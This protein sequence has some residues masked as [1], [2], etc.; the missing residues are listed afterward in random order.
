MSAEDTLSSTG[1]SSGLPLVIVTTL[2]LGVL[3]GSKLALVR[4]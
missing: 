3:R 4:T 2:L 1:V